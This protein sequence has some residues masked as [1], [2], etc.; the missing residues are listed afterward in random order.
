MKIQSNKETYEVD[1]RHDGRWYH[2]NALY[3]GCCH[4]PGDIV[5][6]VKPVHYKIYTHS[7][8]AIFHGNGWLDVDHVRPASREEILNELLE[9]AR[10]KRLQHAADVIYKLKE[11][12]RLL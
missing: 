4:S 12:N 11:Q 10:V 5:W 3:P 2:V 1:F 7:L 8:I 6:G 9:R